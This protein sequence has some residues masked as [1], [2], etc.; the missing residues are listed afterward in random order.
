ME[1]LH[2]WA[3]KALKCHKQNLMEHSVGILADKNA[4]RPVEKGGLDPEMS[5]VNKDC[6]ELAIFWQKN[7]S[8]CVLP[9]S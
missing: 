5:E 1:S 4:E 8:E 6:L 2:P 3:T 7:L 9:I